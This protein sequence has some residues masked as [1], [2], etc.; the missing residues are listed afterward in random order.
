VNR[1][2][3]RAWTAQP[4]ALERSGGFRHFALVREWGQ[5]EGRR[6]ELEAVLQRSFRLVLPPAELANRE[7][8]QSGWLRLPQDP[9]DLLQDQ[10]EAASQA[11]G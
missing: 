1:K 7:H 6:I 8:W 3:P 9:P 11:S 2:R 10:G 5:G 4:A